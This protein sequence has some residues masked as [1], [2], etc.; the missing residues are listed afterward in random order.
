MCEGRSDEDELGGGRRLATNV[1]ENR[2]GHK[3]RFF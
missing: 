2:N 1:R 3:E